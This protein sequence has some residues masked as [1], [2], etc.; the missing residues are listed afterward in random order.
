MACLLY[1][2]KTQE[3]RVKLLANRAGSRWISMGA[4]EIGTHPGGPSND[5]LHGSQC[6]DLVIQFDSL[7]N[8]E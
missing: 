4:R 3:K 5:N 7:K 8:E 1:L 2:E 6:T